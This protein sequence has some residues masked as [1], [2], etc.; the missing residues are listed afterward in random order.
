MGKI[1]VIVMSESLIAVFYEYIFSRNILATFQ[2]E[3]FYPNAS[4]KKFARPLK[5]FADR[6]FGYPPN[7][8]T[9]RKFLPDPPSITDTYLEIKGSKIR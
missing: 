8:H 3:L 2:L 6:H 4:W 9:F 1:G 7:R 5:K